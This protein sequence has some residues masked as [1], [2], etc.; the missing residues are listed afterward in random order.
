MNISCNRLIISKTTAVYELKALEPASMANMQM[1]DP[2]IHVVK[3]YKNN[4]TIYIYSQFLHSQSW[5]SEGLL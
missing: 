4:P 3:T 5:K 2:S 1:W